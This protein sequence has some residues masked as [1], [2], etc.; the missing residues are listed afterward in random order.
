M[1]LNSFLCSINLLLLNSRLPSKFILSS[2]SLG[3]PIGLSS[4]SQKNSPNSADPG[5][6]W[7]TRRYSLTSSCASANC[8]SS[9]LF[10]Y[11]SNEQIT[12]A[13]LPTAT[14]LSGISP[15]TILPAPMITLFPIFTPLRIKE[16][17][18]I[19]TLLPIVTFPDDPRTSPYTL[20]ITDQSYPCVR[21]VTPRVIC[22][23]FPISISHGRVISIPTC[24]GEY[25]NTLSPIRAPLFLRYF[26]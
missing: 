17:I 8:A 1:L 24:I 23:S 22:T 25:T 13:G 26:K 3:N 4:N 18:P 14:Q 7:Y 16:F 19:N 10:R 12:L 2:H 5:S 20:L 9:R 11:S 21:I 15:V 6:L